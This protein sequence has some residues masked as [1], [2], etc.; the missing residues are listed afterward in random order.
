MI[1]FGLVLLLFLICAGVGV[2]LFKEACSRQELDLEN[3]DAVRS[4]P[5]GKYACEIIAARH[6]IEQHP[7]ENWTTESF[8]GLK[9]QAIW[10][11]AENARATVILAHGY[12][13][14][15][16][17][18]FGPVLEEYH[19]RGLNLLLP[20]QRSH[21]KSEGKYITYGVKESRDMLSW[22]R[23]HN[24]RF[25][26]TPILCSGL[27]MGAS[28]MMYLAGMELPTNVKAFAVDCGF[29]SPKEIISHVFCQ[30]VH[31]PAWPFL[32]TTELCARYFAGFSLNECHSV[33]TLAKNLL[34]ILMVH[35]LTDTFVPAEMTK[36][37]F[38]AC[39]GDKRLLLVENAGHGLSFW[40]EKEAY[41]KQLDEIIEKVWSE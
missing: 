41:L 4:G 3:D 27:S 6:F 36:R 21:G 31:L 13:S 35:G 24:R 40:I 34:P 8:D 39:G 32:W 22:I 11:P 7:H 26:T 30:R 18:D 16:L 1:F 5:Y 15:F 19:R 33:K 9:L 14:N 17:V 2:Y 12:H 38:A 25:E 37:G 10:I 23:L 20:Y 28:T 29:T